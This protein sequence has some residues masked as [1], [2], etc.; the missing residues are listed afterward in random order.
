M[1]ALKQVEHLVSAKLAVIKTLLEL[2]RLEVRLAGLSVFP[3]LLSLCL[4]LVVLMT[5]WL[6]L[7]LL[8]G[9]G[10]LMAFHNILLSLGGVFLIN[11]GIVLYLFKSL[12][13]NLKNMSFEKSRSYFSQNASIDY[14]QLEKTVNRSN[15][16][17]E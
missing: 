5:A 3:L 11:L 4:V 2:V 13:F 12:A 9:Y 6:S 1:E 17:E 14:E 7:S 8:M 16:N 10:I 15:S